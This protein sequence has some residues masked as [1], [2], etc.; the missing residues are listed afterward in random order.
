L[1]DLSGFST[2]LQPF[3]QYTGGLNVFDSNDYSWY[4]GLQVIF[5]R[6][7]TNGLGFQFAYTLSKSKDTRSWDPSL[8][9]VSTGST[10]SASSTP[11]NNL[12]RSLNYSWSDFDRRHVFQGTWVWELPV[13]R[14]KWL[15]PGAGVG[16]YILGG[17][18]LSGTVLWESGRPFSVYSGANTFSSV[19]QSFANCTGCTRDMGKLIV[20]SGKNFWFDS[21]QR[22]M[23]SPP[24]P[25]T[26][27]NLPRNFFLAPPYFAVNA[28]LLK[29]FRIN[30][31]VSL[32]ARLD[33]TNL[34]NHPS[35]DNPTAVINSSIFG[36]INDSVTSSP[37]RMQAS[38]KLNF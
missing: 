32:D 27:G 20:E 31:R 13:G 37:R 35:F 25:G 8:S 38:L 16:N 1:L 23:F 14:G 28:S 10:Q 30:E 29:K 15:S 24:D 26:L 17:W 34:T 6:R 21:T 33:A 9:T 2:L 12:D 5:R 19:V 22:A 36:R 18:Q 3:P 7:I 11:Q 4:H